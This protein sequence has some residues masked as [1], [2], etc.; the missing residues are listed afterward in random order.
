MG[1]PRRFPSSSQLWSLNNSFFKKR[2]RSREAPRSALRCPAVPAAPGPAALRPRRAYS[3]PAAASSSSA[4]APCRCFPGW[5]RL[6]LLQFPLLPSSHFLF[7]APGGNGT[8]SAPPRRE[9]P[10]RRLRE[11]RLPRGLRAAP[12]VIKAY[13]Y[14][15]C[16][17]L[18]LLRPPFLSKNAASVVLKWPQ[19]SCWCSCEHPSLFFST[20]FCTVMFWMSR[21]LRPQGF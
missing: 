13:F 14:H 3:A 20:H 18:E 17:F 9:G 12:T 7:P 19:G 11:R 4:L 16:L 6:L 2:T 1:S 15:K 8:G 5:R 10:R 21:L